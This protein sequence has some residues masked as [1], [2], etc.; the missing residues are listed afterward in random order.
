MNMVVFIGPTLPPD[1]ARLLAPDIQFEGPAA[2]G[3]VYRATTRH[4]TALGIIDGY[5]EHQLPVWHKE[6]LWALRHGIRVYGASSLGALRAAELAPFGMIGVGLIYEAFR[7]GELT[8]DD[9]VVLSH[10]PAERNYQPTSEPLVNLRATLDRARADG[11]IRPT[12]RD[13]LIGEAKALFY[14]ERTYAA[15][16]LRAQAE[17][18]PEAELTALDRWL[19]AGHRVDQKRLDA[20]ALLQRMRDDQLAAEPA[21]PPEFSFAYTEA[22][23]ELRT[24]LDRRAPGA[25]S[26]RRRGR[27]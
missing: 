21:R 7:A 2:C 27:D 22:W 10:Q 24:E 18:A 5:F 15:V 9:E 26:S 12:T 8:E 13:L 6:V 14:P 3:D 19:Q 11:V 16:L 25:R 1:Q 20:L 23:H 4:V 17:G